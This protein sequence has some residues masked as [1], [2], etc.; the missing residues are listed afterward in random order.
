[1]ELKSSAKGEIVILWPH[2]NYAIQ[3][4]SY[5]VEFR[6]STVLTDERVQNIDFGRCSR[7]EPSRAV[8]KTP[9]SIVVSGIWQRIFLLRFVINYDRMT[10]MRLPRS[11]RH[12]KAT[13]TFVVRVGVTEFRGIV[14]SN[15]GQP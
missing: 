14:I 15:A 9:L 3:F 5:F 11:L 10:V 12:V 2:L 7:A 4:C 1:M 13:P 6:S 8:H